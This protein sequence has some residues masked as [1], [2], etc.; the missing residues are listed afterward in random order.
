MRIW[1]SQPRPLI[2]ANIGGGISKGLRGWGCIGR[3]RCRGAI[4]LCIFIQ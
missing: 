3:G 1:D 2:W 4:A